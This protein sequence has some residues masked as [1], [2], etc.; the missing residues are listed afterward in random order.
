MSFLYVQDE[1]TLREHQELWC[2]LQEITSC[3]ICCKGLKAPVKHCCNGHTI[4][5]N[6][7]IRVRHCPICRGNF[8]T[9]KVRVLEN[10][11][12]LLPHKN[13]HE[14]CEN[15]K[16]EIVMKA[17]D[18][19]AKCCGFQIS[20]GGLIFIFVFLPFILWF[21]IFKYVMNTRWT[22]SRY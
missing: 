17:E 19:N 5:N 2:K 10:V 14:N 21:S 6:C 9:L 20:T 18:D 4:C 13:E 22:R 16:V 11:L 3:P 7:H 15:T 8:I 12:D 1:L